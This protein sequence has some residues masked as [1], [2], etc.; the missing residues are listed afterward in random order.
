[1]GKVMIVTGGSRGIGAATVQLAAEAGYAI[2]FSYGAS[3]EAARK[4]VADAEKAGAK[5]VAVQADMGTEEG[6]LKLFRA[7]DDAFG[8]LDVLINNAG[9]TGKVGRVAD[10]SAAELRKVLDIN[11]FGYLVAAREAVRRMSTKL[12]GDGGTIVN[13]SSRAAALG[14]PNEFVQYAASKG[15][16]DSMTIGLARELGAEGIRVNAVRPGLIDTEIHALAGAPDR[17]ERF[18]SGV[19]MGRSGSAEEVAQTIMWLASEGSSYVSGAL[20]DVSGGR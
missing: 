4:V 14:S 3:E 19:P 6:I 12:G 11:V 17:V 5:V 7:S 13:V 16:T 2:C 10:L 18:M 1:M 8:R 15:A 9:I 20:L